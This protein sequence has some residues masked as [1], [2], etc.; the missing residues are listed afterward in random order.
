[1]LA[2]PQGS[3]NIYFHGPHCR[4]S[5][6]ERDQNMGNGCWD[7]ASLQPAVTSVVMKGFGSRPGVHCNI[8]GALKCF[9][10]CDG[11]LPAGGWPAKRGCDKRFG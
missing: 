4:H 11:L 5:E 1:M 3:C 6:P 8:P 10:A 9:L 2:A 7:L